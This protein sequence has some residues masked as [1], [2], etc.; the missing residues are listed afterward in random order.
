MILQ[1]LSEY[2]GVS[3]SIFKQKGIFDAIIGV[4]SGFYLDPTLL[5]NTRIPEFK[6]SYK[7]IE[8]HYENVFLLLKLAN[9]DHNS[10]P[11]KVALKECIFQEPIGTFLGYGNKTCGRGVGKKLAQQLLISAEKIWQM[12]IDDPQIIALLGILEEGF[13][14]DRISDMTINI[15]QDNILNYT[16]RITKILKL[17]Y[18]NHFFIKGKIY[19]LPINPQYPTKFLILIPTNFLRT[20]PS[21]DEYI[22]NPCTQNEELRKRVNK[23]LGV[24]LYKAPKNSIKLAI[25]NDKNNIY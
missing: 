12:G 7:K 21:F 11:W 23:I 16:Q 13:G 24:S 18:T 1:R 6:G 9:K 14:A 3:K 25:L 22:Y 19:K 20:L 10:K 2:F 8:R 5:K 15:I 17:K 4:D